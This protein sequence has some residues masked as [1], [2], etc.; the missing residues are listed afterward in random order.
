MVRELEPPFPRSITI[1][2]QSV[3][4]ILKSILV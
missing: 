4:C 3:F 1:A 2:L